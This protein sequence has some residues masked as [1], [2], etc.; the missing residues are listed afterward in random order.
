MLASSLLASAGLA[1][2]G[3][4]DSGTMVA[5]APMTVGSAA[6]T[7]NMLPD[8]Y[9]CH[10]KGT[11]PPI[12]WSGAPSGTKGF[13]L[14]IDDSSAPNDPFIYW[15][16]VGISDAS[17]DIQEGSLPPGATQALN[18]A[19]TA[20]Y[21]PPCPQGAPHSYRITVYALNTALNLPDG[22]ALTTAWSDIAAATI[23]RG[24]KVV[25][26]KPLSGHLFRNYLWSEVWHSWDTIRS[27]RQQSGQAG[28]TALATTGGGS[29]HR[30]R[31]PS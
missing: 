29:R 23:G 12:T 22:T 21:D 9:T 18:S 11:S 6:F 1:G 13:A 17:T 31:V 15:I 30:P 28:I 19:G 27:G 8:T 10:G 3:F 14:V 24:R 16:V 5:P 25:T 4:L 2:C 20:R 7:Q 26:G